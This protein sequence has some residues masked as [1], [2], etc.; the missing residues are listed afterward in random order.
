MDFESFYSLTPQT[1]CAAKVEPLCS[2]ESINAIGSIIKAEL[3][4]PPLLVSEERMNQR[5]RPMLAGE[6]GETVIVVSGK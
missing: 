3:S 4:G 5:G 6:V 2:R 1:E